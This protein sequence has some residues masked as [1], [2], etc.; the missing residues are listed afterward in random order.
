M[1]LLGI[2]GACSKISLVLWMFTQ[3]FRFAYEPFVFAH[4][5][6][7]DSK[8][9][10]ANAMKY[11]II[12]SLIIFLGMEFY[13][14]ALKLII[15]KNY[16]EGFS[17]VPIILMSYVFQGIYFNLSFWYK[18][19]DKTMYG[20]YFSTLGAIITVVIIVVFVPYKSPV[21]GGYMAAA[22]ASFICYFVM[23]VISYIYGQKYFPVQYELKRIGWYFILAVLLFFI[24]TWDKMT[25]HVPSIDYSIKTIVFL[26]FIYYLLWKEMLLDK[27]PILNKYLQK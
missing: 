14:D 18:L 4:Q 3:A 7:S 6:K 19:T 15:N 2:Y 5:E 9:A 10:Y 23:M 13:I 17:V 27:I 1:R 12:F 11:F 24:F 22:W 26:G 20:A 21:Y 16:W 25:T 8:L